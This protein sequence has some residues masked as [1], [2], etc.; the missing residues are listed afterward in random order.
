MILHAAGETGPAPPGSVAIVLTAKNEAELLELA[1][2]DP[3]AHP[4][5]ECDGPYAGQT[6]AIGFPPC[7]DRRTIFRHLRLWKGAP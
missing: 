2:L 1:K 3:D 5:T 6:L 4:I 7:V